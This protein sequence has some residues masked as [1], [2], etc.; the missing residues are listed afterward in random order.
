M[1][2]PLSCPRFFLPRSDP[3]VSHFFLEKKKISFPAPETGLLVDKCL[4]LVFFFRRPAPA[5]IYLGKGGE[6]AFFAKYIQQ[7]PRVKLSVGISF[8]L[9]PDH[10]LTEIPAAAAVPRQSVFSK[11]PPRVGKK[12]KPFVTG[13][14]YRHR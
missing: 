14:F 7:S 8:C 4:H 6:C 12:R 10:H 11:Y 5:S 2:P 9:S 13:Q 1:G 3:P